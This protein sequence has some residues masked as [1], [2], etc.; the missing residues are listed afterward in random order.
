MCGGRTKGY[1]H[2]ELDTVLR[3]EF[4]IQVLEK[5]YDL[6]D[7]CFSK[8]RQHLTLRT[9]GLYFLYFQHF[10]SKKKSTRSLNIQ[11]GVIASNTDRWIRMFI[12]PPLQSRLKTMSLKKTFERQSVTQKTKTLKSGE[13]HN[14]HLLKQNT[15][16]RAASCWQFCCSNS[17]KNW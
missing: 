9:H 17:A 11:L 13:H 8:M 3:H 6:H 14:S 2:V 16:Q 10:H 12:Q 15:I 1:L 5:Q 4:V 7:Y